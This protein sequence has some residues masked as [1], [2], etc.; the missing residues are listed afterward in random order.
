MNWLAIQTIGREAKSFDSKLPKSA[1][2]CR[3]SNAM[4]LSL[5][6]SAMLLHPVPYSSSITLVRT[7]ST[8]DAG[9]RSHL[10]AS[11]SYPE[12]NSTSVPRPVDVGDLN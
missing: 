9:A 2:A 1:W 3:F 7:L 4:C 6:R 11:L 5:S 12:T 10:L 8:P